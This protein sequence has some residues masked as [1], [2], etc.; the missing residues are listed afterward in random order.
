VA[1]KTILFQESQHTGDKKIAGH[2]MQRAYAEAAITFA[3]VHPNVISTYKHE[4][5]MM[6]PEDRSYEGNGEGGGARD[7][8]LFLVQVP[9]DKRPPKLYVDAV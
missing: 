4:I 9:Y 8:K 2:N 6:Q 7:M 3:L 5:K 1:V